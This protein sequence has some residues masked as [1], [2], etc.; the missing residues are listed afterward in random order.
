MKLTALYTVFLVA[1]LSVGCVTPPR[2]YVP[3]D[4]WDVTFLG[5]AWKLDHAGQNNMQRISEY[6]PQ[7]Q[8]V[9]NWKEIVTRQFVAARFETSTRFMETN[10]RDLSRS[11][12]GFQS[13]V[14]E[15]NGYESLYEWWHP[16]SG[17]WPAEHQITLAKYHPNGIHVLSYATKNVPIDPKTRERWVEQMR[18]VKLR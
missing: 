12:D 13:N 9:E 17:K 14:I 4:D 16:N 10:L 3:P 1:A 2:D 18:S 7:D 11:V 8:S 15:D 5:G 6:V